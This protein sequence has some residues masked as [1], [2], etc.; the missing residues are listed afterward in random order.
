MF[1]QILSLVFLII[2]SP[3]LII[4]SIIIVID[5]GFPIIF[6]QKRI[7]KGNRFFMIYK[8]RTM[9][10]NTPDIPTH[11]MVNSRNIYTKIGPFMRKFS[12]DELPQLFN[13]LNCDIKFIGPRPA[14][15]N[16]EDLIRLRTEKGI[17]LISPG[18]TGWAQVNG[19]DQLSIAEKIKMDE[20]YLINRSIFLNVK[21]IW[22]TLFKIV[23]AE[24][25]SI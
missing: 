13:I 14:L 16:Q 12:L 25:V 20:Y 19:R 1:N 18:I 21:I 6:K 7:G 5:D 8:F 4:I 23:K 24:D 15:Y 11:M 2:L 22:L 17:H 10:K 3:L 9:K